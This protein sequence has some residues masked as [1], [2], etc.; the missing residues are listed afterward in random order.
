MKIRTIALIGTVFA[1]VGGVGVVARSSST[2]NG[3]TGTSDDAGGGSDS[4]GNTNPDSG[5]NTNPDSGG[6][7]NPDGGNVSDDAG[8]CKS[9]ALH[10]PEADGGIYCPFSYN[11]ATDAGTQYCGSG[12]NAALGQ[13]CLSGGGDAGPSICQAFDKTAGDFNGGL[14]GCGATYEAAWQCG[15]PLDCTNGVGPALPIDGGAPTTGATVCCLVGGALAADTSAGVC[16][17]VQKTHFGGTTCQPADACHGSVSVV[18]A[19]KSYVDPLYVA[20][21][22]N[23]DCTGTGQTCTAIYVTGTAIGVCLPAQ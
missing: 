8:P 9:P 20:C 6:N 13:C 23:S 1:M 22:Q 12:A 10:V 17:T 5:G 11:D 7:T 4:G 15:S 3:G 19:G 2:N 16:S 14:A 21:E 18:S